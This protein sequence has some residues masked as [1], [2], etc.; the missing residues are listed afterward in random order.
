MIE[1]NNK[2]SRRKQSKPIR[3]QHNNAPD[4]GEHHPVNETEVERPKSNPGFENDSS[5]SFMD[6]DHSIACIICSETFPSQELMKDHFMAVHAT[7]M[8]GGT[9]FRMHFPTEYHRLGHDMHPESD[10]KDPYENERRNE[11]GGSGGSGDQ[12]DSGVESGTPS[13]NTQLKDSGELNPGEI[14]RSQN[15]TRIFHPDAYCELCDREFCN[16]YFLKTHK[17]N[18]HGIYDSPLPMVSQPGPL[19][20]PMFPMFFSQPGPLHAPPEPIPTSMSSMVPQ[21]SA[22]KQSPPLHMEPQKQMPISAPAPESNSSSQQKDLEDYCEICQKHFCNKYYLRK[23]K[24]D[25]HGIQSEP[26]SKRQRSSIT[27]DSLKHLNN[28][29]TSPVLLPQNIPNSMTNVMLINPFAPLM[30]LPQMPN[31]SLLSAHLPQLPQTSTPIKSPPHPQ[32]MMGNQNEQ[33]DNNSSA[34]PGAM[35]QDE[36]RRMGVLNTDAFCELCRK[37]FC[38][39]YFLKIH[40]ANKHGI[41]SYDDHFLMNGMRRSPTGPPP[42]NMSTSSSPVDHSMNNALDLKMNNNHEKKESSISNEQETP[43]K[44]EPTDQDREKERDSDANNHNQGSPAALCDICNKDFETVQMLRIHHLTAH[45]SFVDDQKPSM[46]VFDA[47]KPSTQLPQSLPTDHPSP[48]PGMMSD[49]PGMPTMFSSMIAAKLADRV[50]CDLCNK[51]VCNKYFLKTHKIKM[52]GVDPNSFRETGRERESCNNLPEKS[53]VIVENKTATEQQERLDESKTQ[54]HQPPVSNPSQMVQEHFPPKPQHDSSNST[55]IK[56]QRNEELLK[57]GIDP[58]AYC[59]LCKKEFCS[60]YFLRTHMF[61]MHGIRVEGLK[62]K[63]I[64][65]VHEKQMR[66]IKEREMKILDLSRPPPPLPSH[67]APPPQ[68]MHPFTSLQMQ[69]HEQFAQSRMRQEESNDSMD[70]RSVTSDTSAGGKSRE[71]AN[72]IRVKCDICSKEL[73]NKYFLRTHKLNKHGILDE[74]LARESYSMF[75]FPKNLID[76]WM[77]GRPTY[78]DKY[79]KK[80]SFEGYPPEFKGK[81]GLPASPTESKPSGYDSTSHLPNQPSPPPSSMFDRQ[82]DSPDGSTPQMYGESCHICHRRFKNSKWLKAHLYTEHNIKGEQISDMND[83]PFQACELCGM[84]FP[85]KSV[86]RMHLMQVHRVQMGPII[87]EMPKPLDLGKTSVVPHK[88]KSIDE[89]LDNTQNYAA[90]NISLSLKRKYSKNIKQKLHSCSHCDYKTRWLSNIYSHEERKH[91]INKQT[92]GRFTCNKCF[93]CFRY[94][95]SLYRHDIEYHKGK[96][97]GLIKASALS[98]LNRSLKEKKRFRCAHCQERFSS[99]QDCRLHIRS[100][101]K[102]RSAGPSRKYQCQKCDYSSN[103]TK[104][105]RNHMKIKHKDTHI[106]NLPING[107]ANANT[108]EVDE[109]ELPVSYATPCDLKTQSSFIMQPFTLKDDTMGNMKQFVTAVVYLPVKQKINERVNVTFELSPTEQ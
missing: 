57:M 45:G 28:M 75:D 63:D 78:I 100:A 9:D 13:M 31:A 99:R 96:F 56:M 51:E 39:K 40:K 48:I 84:V 67:V 6:T 104:N 68:H 107:D 66:E 72:M 1:K 71:P 94:E 41:Y 81:Y 109:N 34:S 14:N 18:K 37:E 55:P 29:A 49:V 23:H 47:E 90:S 35:S 10:M 108:T 60:K 53:N 36:L 16:K 58:E 87:S 65:K 33:R 52:H 77:N 74:S 70:N 73:C 7:A 32:A 38:N 50:M 103:L 3:V 27:S 54:Q 101:H 30:A 85:D 61:N 79:V 8:A 2:S 25:V 80:E 62:E 15:G 12:Q 44:E 21:P 43:T 4:M 76:N 42:V 92:Q 64:K 105:L 88:S 26:H 22:E 102:S 17:A 93:K 91:N 83:G 86:L 11:S 89:C 98:S 59:E 106:E 69:M 20:A 46:P 97:S 5:S 19:P 24:A 95:H 82:C